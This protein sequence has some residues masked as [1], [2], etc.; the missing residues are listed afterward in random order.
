MPQLPKFHLILWFVSP[1]PRLHVSLSQTKIT[2]QPSSSNSLSTSSNSLNISFKILHSILVL[3]LLVGAAQESHQQAQNVS[4]VK[5]RT[6]GQ[7]IAR[8]LHVISVVSQAT[9]SKHVP[10]SP[11]REEQPNLWGRQGECGS[12][13]ASFAGQ[14]LV[15]MASKEPSQ[16]IM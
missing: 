8:Q 14:L 9:P 10:R 16:G 13:P 3:K 7:T 2:L 11:V 1:L 15:L 12:R 6:I 5:V 4:G